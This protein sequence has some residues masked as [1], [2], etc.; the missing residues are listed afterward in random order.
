MN[1]EVM[2]TQ[3]FHMCNMSTLSCILSTSV[4][5]HIAFWWCIDE[6]AL[7]ISKLRRLE[8]PYS[9]YI[10]VSLLWSDLRMWGIGHAGLRAYDRPWRPSRGTGME[11]YDHLDCVVWPCLKYN[12][13]WCISH[14]TT[15]LLLFSHSSTWH[16]T[17]ACRHAVLFLPH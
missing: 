7:V 6:H 17:H 15:F 8:M 10:T 14:R 1:S 3:W 12:S 11:S 2:W 5:F 9:H 4:R 13:R 16:F